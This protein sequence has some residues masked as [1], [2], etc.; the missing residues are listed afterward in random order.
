M[1]LFR[2]D[3]IFNYFLYKNSV[4]PQNCVI[5]YFK[6]LAERSNRKV[7]D[8]VVQMDLAIERISI[9]GEAAVKAAGDKEANI[10][11]TAAMCRRYIEN[12]I[13]YRK[14]LRGW[15]SIILDEI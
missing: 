13:K 14:Y 15:L 1:N 7:Y 5:P 3:N 10:S 9:E 6:K 4:Y 11:E 8:T 2:H 12:L